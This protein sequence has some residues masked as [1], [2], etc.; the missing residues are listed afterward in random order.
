METRQ[1][2][3]SALFPGKNI[4]QCYKCLDKWSYTRSDKAVCQLTTM[5]QKWLK[6]FVLMKQKHLNAKTSFLKRLLV[7]FK[8]NI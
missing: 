5:F 7:T 6:L 3:L 1:T 2:H 4:A 8:G